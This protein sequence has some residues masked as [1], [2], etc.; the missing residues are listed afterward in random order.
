M[1]EKL[2]YSGLNIYQRMSAIMAEI[3]SVS[4]NLMIVTGKSSYKAV[5]EADILAAV[6]PIEE[7]YG[8]YSYPVERRIVESG[9]MERE[10]Q[11]GKTIQLYMRLETTYRFL[12]ID[13]PDS[14]VDIISYGDGVDTQDKSPGKAMTYS[15]KYAL[16]K[17]YKIVTGDDPDQYKSEEYENLNKNKPSN[18]KETRYNQKPKEEKASQKSK[19]EDYPSREELY[20]F[21]VKNYDAKNQTSIL[22]Y[23]GVDSLDDL[24][25]EQLIRCY[26]QKGGKKK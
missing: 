2:I 17:A 1:A 9:T 23:Y 6:K 4:K 20:D 15:D 21:V 16:M 22:A 18:K 7:K 19:R 14:Y 26:V 3:T 11:Y 5:G 12:C 25:D 8:V 10:N 24:S 13:D